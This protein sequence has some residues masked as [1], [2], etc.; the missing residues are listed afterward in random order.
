MVKKII[1]ELEKEDRRFYRKIRKL[2]D[3]NTREF[4]KSMEQIRIGLR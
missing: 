4:E 2:M 1:E 3:E